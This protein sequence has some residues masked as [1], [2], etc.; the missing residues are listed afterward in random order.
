M[1]TQLRGIFNRDTS[2][3]MEALQQSISRLLADYRLNWLHVYR[4]KRTMT[5]NCPNVYMNFTIFW[6]LSNCTPS[7]HSPSN[8]EVF[9]FH[10]ANATTIHTGQ[11]PSQFSTTHFWINTVK[12]TPLQYTECKNIIAISGARKSDW[13]SRSTITW[14]SPTKSRSHQP[15]VSRVVDLQTRVARKEEPSQVTTRPRMRSTSSFCL[16]FSQKET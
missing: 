8:F 7:L 12:W 10:M 11:I 14:Q 9:S 2:T 1:C 15:N 16:S 5:Q 6:K 13:T 3:T 4:Y